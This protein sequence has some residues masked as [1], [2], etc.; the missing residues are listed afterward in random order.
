MKKIGRPAC[1]V[2]GGEV[3]RPEG[4]VM[5]YCTNAACPAQLRSGWG[6]L[7]PAGRWISGASVNQWRLH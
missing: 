4:E 3:I 2:C 6:I 7:P 5:Y 1:P